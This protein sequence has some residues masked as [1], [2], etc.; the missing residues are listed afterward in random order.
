MPRELDFRLKKN[1]DF[2]LSFTAKD[3]DGAAV[4]LAGATIKWS[5]KET[6]DE[7]AT[8]LITKSTGG[9]G[10][11]VTNAAAGIFQVE[12]ADTDTEDLAVGKYVHEATITTSG[13][14]IIS[15]TDQD[16]DAGYVLLVAQYTAP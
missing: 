13:G 11:T 7:D 14:R 5:M 16:G 15:L 12:I 10:V 3:Q 6:D 8:A 1:T 4:N 9:A 2:T